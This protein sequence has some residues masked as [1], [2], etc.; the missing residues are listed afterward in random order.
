MFVFFFIYLKNMQFCKNLIGAIKIYFFLIIF[1][2]AGLPIK[3]IFLMGLTSLKE[4]Y[5]N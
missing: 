4:N 5:E 1:F 3:T 2:F